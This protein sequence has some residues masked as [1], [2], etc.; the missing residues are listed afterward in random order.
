MRVSL[1]VSR[2]R[3]NLPE[4]SSL[5]SLLNFLMSTNTMLDD[6]S[7]LIL[8]PIFRDKSFRQISGESEICNASATLEVSGKLNFY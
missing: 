6:N 3:V 7:T 4:M 5:F 1:A 8:C 2:V